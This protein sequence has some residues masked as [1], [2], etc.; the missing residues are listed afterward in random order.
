MNPATDHRRVTDAAEEA[1]LRRLGADATQLAL[2][3]RSPAEFFGELLH[4]LLE[5]LAAPFG[6]AWLRIPAGHIQRL[7]QISPNNVAG[8]VSDA[9]RA[10]YDDQVRQAVQLGRPLYFSAAGTQGA[11]DTKTTESRSAS[12]WAIFFVPIFHNE[13]VEGLLELWQAPG[14]EA[15]AL[16]ATMQLLV[17]MADLAGVYLASRD[18]QP[19]NEPEEVWDRLNAFALRIHSSL[20]PTEVAY[21][22]A[23]EGRQI[24]ACDRLSVALRQDRRVAI[25]AVSGAERVDARSN[26]VRCMR[27]LCD[28][29]LDWGEPLHYQGQQDESLPGEVLRELDA[30]VEVSHAKYLVIRPL[31][32]ERKPREP[33]PARAAL[34]LEC[35]EPTMPFEPLAARLDVL[36][37][38]A[39]YALYNA[40]AYRQVPLRFL[41]RPIARVQEGLGGKTKAIIAACTVAALILIACLI[42]VPY[43]L[44]MDAKGQLLP[45]Q[46]RWVYSPVDGQVVRFEN[47]VEPGRHVHANQSLILMYD[48]QLEAKLTQLR[49]EAAAAQ[50]DVSS[51]AK[52]LTTA[53]TEADRLR[54][55]A[56]KKQKEAIRDHKYWELKSLRERTNSEESRPGYFWLKAPLGG[57]VLSWDF[58]EN[59][60]SRQVRP[61]EPLLRLGDKNQDW[62][63]ELKIPEKH[64]G[65]IVRAFEALDPKTELD[66][67][68]LVTSEPTR[69]YKGKLTSVRLAGEASPMR[70]E[71]GDAEPVVLAS[72]RIKG[73]DISAEDQ[74]PATLLVSGTEVHAKVRCG[75]RALGYALFYGLW[76]FVF[77]KVVF[78]F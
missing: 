15:P 18:R 67:D 8:H 55:S 70:E 46:R 47:G 45:E 26:V 1:K 78:F 49:Q 34:V 38:H 16:L 74:I 12:S 17:R 36:A 44:K 33:R 53:A 2:S 31:P 51:L 43:P 65:Q 6:S 69:I 50:Q 58:R 57:T 37:P 21:L 48:V 19:Q 68:L 10:R 27:R 60:T 32:D 56:E 30:Y 73:P 14:A 76:E 9:E 20:Q 64:I 13:Q 42:F 54:L 66:V 4:R 40:S 61:S 77:E 41:W 72:V 3:E 63:V 29:V 24:V 23:N 71:A 75:N 35:F 7:C 5:A 52:Q 28:R 59:L 62:E 39:A 22:I 11:A 25:E